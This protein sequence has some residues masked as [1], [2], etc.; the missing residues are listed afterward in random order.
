MIRKLRI[1][2]VAAAMLSLLVVL[3]AIVGTAGVINYRNIISDADFRLQL[4]TDNSGM[5][6]ADLNDQGRHFSP[7]MPFEMRFFTV[8]YSGSDSAPTVNTGRIAAV[9]EEQAVS[10]ADQ[11]MAGGSTSGFVATYRYIV[12]ENAAGAGSKQVYFLDCYRELQSFHNFL[13]TSIAV[14]AAGFLA[15]LLLLILTSQRIIRPVSESYEKQ[16]R[17]ITDAGHELKTPL[18]VISADT[19]VL[20]MDYGENEWLDDIR[21]QTT[22]LADLTNSLVFL[23][24]MEEQPQMEYTEFSLS[25]AAQEAA[26][27]YK[28]VAESK[29][30]TLSAAVVPD[31][32]MCGDEKTIRRLIAIFLDNAVKYTDEHGEIRLSLD[33]W[34]G[35]LRLQVYNTTEHIDRDSLTHL[36]DR[37]YRTDASRNSKT[38]GYGLGLSIASAIAAS[39][40]GKIT[41]STADEKSLLITVTFPS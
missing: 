23:A 41:A 10:Y 28:T 38:G 12:I 31:L 21:K 35:Q 11:I 5:L 37:F 3:T 9:D 17:F 13:R 22:R 39:H 8:L 6:P 4:L 16:K 26:D 20:E 24:R 19:E 34:R 1:R 27:D 7:E 33:R 29:G 30:K 36:F 2:L 25:D 40:K 32:R 15:V 18:T 14:S